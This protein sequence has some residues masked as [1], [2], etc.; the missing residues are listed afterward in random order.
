MF[1]LYSECTRNFFYVLLGPS[2]TC[3]S[4]DPDQTNHVNGVGIVRPHEKY[5]Y[6]QV[7]GIVRPTEQYKYCQV[8]VKHRI[9]KAIM[10]VTAVTAFQFGCL[11]V[12]NM[13]LIFASAI[14]MFSLDMY[15]Y[16]GTIILL[17]VWN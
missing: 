9:R 16:P 5:A 10:F 15:Q 13:T 11:Y 8:Y 14:L 4:N 17:C 7:V 2:A 3:E 12:Y 6:C 1:Y